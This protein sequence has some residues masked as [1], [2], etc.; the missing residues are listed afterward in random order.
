MKIQSK[1][2][3]ISKISQPLLLV[4]LSGIFSYAIA[5]PDTDKMSSLVS[6]QWLSEH[7]GDANLVLLDVSVEVEEDESGGLRITSGRSNYDKGHITSAGFADL[8]GGLSKKDNEFNFVMPSAE[9]FANEM[10]KLGVDSNSYVVLYDSSNNLWA[11]R[12]WWML[13]WTGFDQASVLDGGLT[14]W[15]A[16]GRPLSTTP[17]KRSKKQFSLKLRPETIAYHDEVLA[18][19]NKKNVDIIDTLP[20]ASYQG[21]YSIYTRRGHITSAINIPFDSLFD[22]MGLYLSADKLNKFNAI[23]R[24]NRV[25]TYC[26]GGV[27][28][29]SVA[30]TMHRLGF[31][32]VAVYMGSLQEWTTDENNPMTINLK[33]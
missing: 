8:M 21:E 15:K 20:P 9:Q 28:A 3:I 2:V 16:E 17:V 19:I 30:L 7:L 26:G 23:N 13:H 11:A 18:S 5:Q 33:E 10:G 29:S 32:N 4:L 27:A 24:N 31:K 22:E 25:I 12:L 14:A 6:T 1:L